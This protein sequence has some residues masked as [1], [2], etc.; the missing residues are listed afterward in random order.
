LDLQRI[1]ARGHI[2][3][4]TGLALKGTAKFESARIGGSVLFNGGAAENQKGYTVE[5][6]NANVMGRVSFLNDF[7]SEGSVSLF[8]TTIGGDLECLQSQLNS[9][10]DPTT[11][12]PITPYALYAEFI[13]VKRRV[14][15]AAGS[16][17]IDGRS[18]LFLPFVANGGLSLAYAK[19][20]G[21]LLC[22]G[23]NT[24]PYTQ[25]LFS[26]EGAQIDGDLILTNLS[27]GNGALI[28]Q[29]TSVHGA[30]G[31]IDVK[32]PEALSRLDLRF[33]YA[34]TY[35]HPPMSWPRPNALLLDGFKY[36]SFGPSFPV[37]RC[38]QWLRQNNPLPL[39]LQPYEQAARVLKDSGYET[40]AK[41]TLI[42][43]SEDLARYGELT[44]WQRLSNYWLGLTV[45]YGYRSHRALI[46]MAYIIFMGAGIFHDGKRNN[47]MVKTN[48][49][50]ASDL[51]KS[52]YPSSNHSSTRWTP[53]FRL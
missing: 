39:S 47:L 8:G 27:L 14:L 37:S 30:L 52:N 33:A 16:S 12:L 24:S 4:G 34:S 19:I 11:K 17:T 2:L 49:S 43:K 46:I 36:S 29:R 5:L 28:L 32:K 20:D 1:E 21:S 51:S 25:D 3:F 53:S 6:A 23:C 31:P 40:E 10:V 38:V 41:Q 9:P 22:R 18:F 44:W 35:D 15:L 7:K 48:T 45:G 50:W 42:A 13:R 26:L